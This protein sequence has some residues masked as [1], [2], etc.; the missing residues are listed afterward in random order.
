MTQLTS[1]NV[2]VTLV[3][4]GQPKGDQKLRPIWTDGQSFA[5]KLSGKLIPV[6]VTG[7]T[8]VRAD[9]R[10]ARISPTGVAKNKRNKDTD[11]FTGWHLCTSKELASVKPSTPMA[12][13]LAEPVRETRAKHTAPK[14]EAPKPRTSAQ[15]AATLKLC[16][17]NLTKAQ[18][19]G[20]AARIERAEKALVTAQEHMGTAKPQL[21]LSA[22]SREDK[23]N[24]IASLSA[25]L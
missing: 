1:T 6:T 25:N 5:V 16:E 11:V 13:M 17:R 24:L 14:A 21:D 19:S 22:M 12:A 7:P 20:N 23:L 9:L 15:R 3:S 4:N 10:A 2:I 8:N 18:A